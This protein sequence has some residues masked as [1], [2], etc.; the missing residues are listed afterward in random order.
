MLMAMKRSTYPETIIVDVSQDIRRT[1]WYMT[2]FLK[3][4]HCSCKYVHLGRMR[5][6]KLHEL[7]ALMG[8]PHEDIVSVPGTFYSGKVLVGN[9]MALPSIGGIVAVVLKTAFDVLKVVLKKAES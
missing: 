6:L 1:S 8:Y 9:M 4:L 3:T 2:G 7:F 5:Q